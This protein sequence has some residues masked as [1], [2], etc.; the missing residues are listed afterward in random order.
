MPMIHEVYKGC[1]KRYY[2]TSTSHRYVLEASWEAVRYL[3][4]SGSIEG[5]IRTIKRKTWDAWV[6][7]RVGKSEYA[8]KWRTLI[9]S[10]VVTSQAVIEPREATSGKL[11]VS[12]TGV[13][14]TIVMETDIK[15][16]MTLLYGVSRYLAFGGPDDE[17][18]LLDLDDYT[19]HRPQV[20]PYIVAKAKLTLSI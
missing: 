20:V 5:Q 2:H 19:A 1:S 9:D 10:I 16:G 8:P 15:P 3:A 17:L 7:K 4:L 13:Q 11:Q 6:D 12:S 14:P 18:M